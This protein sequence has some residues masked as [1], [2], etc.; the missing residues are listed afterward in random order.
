M[1]SRPT[2]KDVA[3]HA[4]VSVATVSRVLNDKETV[5]PALREKV[6]TSTAALGF[7]ANRLARSFRKRS[8]KAIALVVPDIK[9]PFFAAVAHEIEQAAFAHG[10]TLLI[11]NTS[12][13]L[14]RQTQYF[15]LLAEEAVAG[16]IVCTANEHR[17]HQE[18]EQAL[19]RGIAV[20]AIDRRLENVPIDLVLSDNFGGARQAVSHLLALGHRRVAVVTGSDDFAPARERRLGFEQAFRDF[21]VAFDSALIKVTDFRDTGAETATHE[22]WAMPDRP[23]ALF[24]ASGNQATGVLRALNVV[25][26]RIPDD[27]SIV[28][29]DD[30]DWASAF[31]PPITA[32]EQNTAQIGTTA[33][34]LLMRRFAQPSA[35]AEERRVPVRLNARLSCSAPP[36]ANA[37]RGARRARPAARPP[38]VA[39]PPAPPGKRRPH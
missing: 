22:L 23:T 7:R 19:K 1:S 3:R 38:P 25:G 29:F 30:L 21:G 15:D 8:A 10:Y 12:D 35:T 27:M 11:C 37:P 36:Q 26:A 6:Q 16:V 17:A 34:N 5:D 13:S 14:E 31:H 20:V 9:N 28:V 39:E 33:V 4:G 32:V 2:I 24:I 18:V